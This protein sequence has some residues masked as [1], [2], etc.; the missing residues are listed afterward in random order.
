M[1]QEYVID[2]FN[3]VIR[4]YVICNFVNIYLGLDLIE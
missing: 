1:I 3:A 2:E 4:I